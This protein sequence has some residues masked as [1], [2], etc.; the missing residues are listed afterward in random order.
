MKKLF[1]FFIFVLFPALGICQNI[2][3]KPTVDHIFSVTAS[4]GSIYFPGQNFVLYYSPAV[5]YHF[6]DISQ[7]KFLIRNGG[8]VG[9][10][11]PGGP[12]TDTED[13]IDVYHEFSLLYVWGFREEKM[14]IG[15]GSGVSIIQGE[16]MYHKKFNQV[17]IPLEMEWR[18]DFS[19]HISGSFDFHFGFSSKSTSRGFGLNFVVRL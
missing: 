18:Y 10:G 1:P 11:S 13:D 12:T 3:D 7:I 5:S 8:G 15:F 19:K 6:D 4:I 16:Q 2:D 14:H 9:F 17:R